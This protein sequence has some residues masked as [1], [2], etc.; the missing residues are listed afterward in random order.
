MTT[1]VATDRTYGL[2]R[3]TVADLHTCITDTAGEDPQLWPRLCEAA[4]VPADT[5][6]PAALATLFTTA[7]TITTGAVRVAVASLNVRLRAHTALTTR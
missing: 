5:D 3:P 1:D 4:G 7:L 2:A 6:D